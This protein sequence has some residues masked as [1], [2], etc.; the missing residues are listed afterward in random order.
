MRQLLGGPA[1]LSSSAAPP[2]RDPTVSSRLDSRKSRRTL[3]L[4][5]LLAGSGAGHTFEPD[6]LGGELQGR[7][8]FTTDRDGLR[9]YLDPAEPSLASTSNWRRNGPVCRPTRSTRRFAG[10]RR[11]WA[12]TSPRERRGNCVVRPQ[13]GYGHPSFWVRRVTR[14]SLTRRIRLFQDFTGCAPWKHPRL[15]A[16]LL[17][18]QSSSSKTSTYPLSV[19]QLQGAD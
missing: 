2:H 12:G 18:S 19:M 9:P 6:T 5:Y 8:V 3:E 4:A 1:R 11:T 17:E 14:L 7:I 15:N 13:A 10:C 16:N